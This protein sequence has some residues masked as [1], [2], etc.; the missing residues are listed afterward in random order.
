MNINVVLQ[1]KLNEYARRGNDKPTAIY[2]G[3]REHRA[4]YME[5]ERHATKPQQIASYPPRAK[6]CG[7]SV[8]RVDDEHHIAFA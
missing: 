8:Y 5:M 6:W 7:L 3:G 4:L 2:L 1:G